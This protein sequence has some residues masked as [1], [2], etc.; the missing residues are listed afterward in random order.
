LPWVRRRIARAD[1]SD[2][3][4]PKRPDLLPVDPGGLTG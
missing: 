3:P 4:D 2:S 1:A